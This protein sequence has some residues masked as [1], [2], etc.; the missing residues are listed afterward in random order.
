MNV[1]FAFSANGTQG[2]WVAAVGTTLLLSA[3]LSGLLRDRNPEGY[4]Q[5]P[6]T[7]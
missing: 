4:N 6:S 1:A 3:T 5:V 7:E 2:G